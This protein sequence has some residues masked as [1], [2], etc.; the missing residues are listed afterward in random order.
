MQVTRK[1]VSRFI[2]FYN[3]KMN[4]VP[5]FAYQR[6]ILKLRSRGYDTPREL[7]SAM[8]FEVKDDVFAIYFKQ[9]IP[10]FLC[11]V[12][13]IFSSGFKDKSV[14]SSILDYFNVSLTNC[15]VCFL[16]ITGT[17]IS[18]FAALCGAPTMIKRKV[19]AFLL[20]LLSAFL[21]MVTFLIIVGWVWSILWGMNMV[22]MARK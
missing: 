17:A 7:L 1:L 6:N 14:A 8:A 13:T 4:K 15:N 16:S 22:Q 20:N 10:G 12:P 2:S 3:I 5:K 18:A 21:Q 9:S 19:K 11:C